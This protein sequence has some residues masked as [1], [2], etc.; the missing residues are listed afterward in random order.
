[1]ALGLLKSILRYSSVPTLTLQNT[2]AVL[3]L[4]LQQSVEAFPE[5]LIMAPSNAASL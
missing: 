3:A 5:A 4:F 1:M 2:I